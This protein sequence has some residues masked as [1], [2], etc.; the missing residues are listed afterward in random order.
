MFN[1][2]CLWLKSFVVKKTPLEI[3]K[4][5]PEKHLITIKDGKWTTVGD[6]MECDPSRFESI[7]KKRGLDEEEMEQYLEPIL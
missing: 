6:L 3:F 5:E 7:L 1:K 4:A 2:I